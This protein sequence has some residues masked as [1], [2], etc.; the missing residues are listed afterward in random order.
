MDTIATL[1]LWRHF[2]FYGRLGAY[3]GSRNIFS[4][5]PVSLLG[6]STRAGPG[7]SSRWSGRVPAR[8]LRR[9]R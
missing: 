3:S 5:N 1:P 6:D 7:R 9:T 8:D 4:A 2:S